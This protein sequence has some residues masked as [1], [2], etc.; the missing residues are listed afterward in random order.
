[1]AEKTT[2]PMISTS[3]WL[4]LRS[5]FQKTLP[6]QVAPSY[7]KSLLGFTNENTAQSLLSGLRKLGLIDE[8]NRTTPRANDWRSD[9]KYSE[10]CQKMIEEIYPQE[11]ID[12]YSGPN[13]DRNSI[14][15]WF[16]HTAALGDSGAAKVAAFYIMLNEGEVKSTD[17]RKKTNGRPNVHKPS[18]RTVDRA[19]KKAESESKSV[20][21]DSES[22]ND[23]KVLQQPSLHIDLQIHIA[24]DA[25]P[26]QIDAIFASMAKHL[27]K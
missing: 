24:P 5:Q 16:M 13:I 15:Q 20:S 1:M 25:S 9:L 26:E 4:A 12:L 21:V 10:T 11:L 8:D 3:N 19:A 27:Y 7:L 22:Q 6:S 18:E 14:K 17:E 23:K 2:Y